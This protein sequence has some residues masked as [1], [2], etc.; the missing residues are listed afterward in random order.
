MDE[1]VLFVLK[2]CVMEL[3]TNRKNKEMENSMQ[4]LGTELNGH[5]AWKHRTDLVS[6]Q[7]IMGIPHLPTFE[8]ICR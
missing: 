1:R 5:K 3:Y 7:D 8:L 4:A 6:A 2:K